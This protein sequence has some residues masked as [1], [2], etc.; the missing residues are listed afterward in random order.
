MKT[1]REL[2]MAEDE[3]SLIVSA[4]YFNQVDALRELLDAGVHGNVSSV[5]IFGLT[6]LHHAALHGHAECVQLLLRLSGKIFDF[7]IKFPIFL[8]I[9][10]LCTDK[11]L[12][13]FSY[14]LCFSIFL[15]NCLKPNFLW[16]LLLEL[17]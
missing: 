15:C 2:G 1:A 11:K 13:N 17:H 9:L 3:L 6:P 12:V 5:D 8:N 4:I 10:E 14:C 16:G 7:K